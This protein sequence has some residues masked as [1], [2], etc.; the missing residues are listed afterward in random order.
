MT[1]PKHTHRFGDGFEDW[2]TYE[3]PST[4]IPII[5]AGLDRIFA[6]APNTVLHQVKEKFG[7]LRIYANTATLPEVEQIIRETEQAVQDLQEN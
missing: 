5:D 1:E 2:N 4:W 7:G 3:V 6:V